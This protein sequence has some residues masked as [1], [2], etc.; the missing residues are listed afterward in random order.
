MLTFD[1]FDFFEKSGRFFKERALQT[2]PIGAGGSACR[3]RRIS[4]LRDPKRHEHGILE[5]FHYPKDPDPACRL[6]FRSKGV[7]T[8]FESAHAFV[9]GRAAGR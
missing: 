8:L 3:P 9:I 7:N 4:L 5:A 1:F 2:V 6:A